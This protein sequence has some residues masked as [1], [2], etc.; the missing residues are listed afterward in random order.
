M[1]KSE[2]IRFSV[3]CSSRGFPHLVRISLTKQTF[4]L[5][6]PQ[7]KQN[8]ACP[9]PGSLSELERQLLICVFLHDLGHGKLEI[10]LGDVDTTFT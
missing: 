6:R 7:A 3:Y 10:L 4:E 5:C 2:E 1:K 9:G 8:T